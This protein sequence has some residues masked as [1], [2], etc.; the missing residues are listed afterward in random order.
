MFKKVILVR[1]LPSLSAYSYS[2]FKL[3]VTNFLCKQY[4]NKLCAS[5]RKKV[6][7]GERGVAAIN[8]MLRAFTFKSAFYSRTWIGEALIW[9]K[10]TCNLRHGGHAG[11]QEQSKLLCKFC[12]FFYC[13]DPQYGRFVTWLQASNLYAN[14][15]ATIT[16]AAAENH[17][18][19]NVSCR[20]QF[21]AGS[22]PEL[23]LTKS[24]DRKLFIF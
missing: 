13:F 21:P 11:G 15:F 14:A 10:S 18:K 12:E 1:W 19:N 3:Q 9:T 22:K 7:V 4:P 5:R 8:A 6:P 20:H 23:K 2:V 24:D 16:T 17:K